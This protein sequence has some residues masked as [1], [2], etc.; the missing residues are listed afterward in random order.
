MCGS[1]V[2]IQSATAE[3]RREKRKIKITWQKYN[4]C[5]CYAGRK[6]C[7]IVCANRNG[8]NSANLWHPGRNVSLQYLFRPHRRTTYVD[9]AYCYR[10]SSV[11]CRS[12]CLS[13]CLSIGRPVT[14]VNSA[15]TAEPIK[16][17]FGLRTLVDPGNHVHSEPEKKRGSLF[18]SIT[19]AN[20][21]R[22]L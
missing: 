2:D 4:V 14:L 17:P 20:L 6:H 9:A 5:I 8:I 15:K 3:I 22:F 1:M 10:S 16:M 13:V 11:V 19:L 18:L 12:V 7:V 21:N